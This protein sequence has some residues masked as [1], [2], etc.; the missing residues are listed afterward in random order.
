MM[1]HSRRVG[2]LRRVQQGGDR[3][4]LREGHGMVGNGV[5]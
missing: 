5:C 1:E 4:S 3:G 2:D